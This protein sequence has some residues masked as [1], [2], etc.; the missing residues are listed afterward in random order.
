VIGVLSLEF[1]V[2]SSEFGVLSLERISVTVTITSELISKNICYTT[3]VY[4]TDKNYRSK[5]RT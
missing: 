4:Y 3:V 2:L 5:L 1:G